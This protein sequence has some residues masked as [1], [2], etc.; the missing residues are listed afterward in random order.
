MTNCANLKGVWNS[1]TICRT[2]A[3]PICPWKQV[4][5]SKKNISN[6]RQSKNDSVK[7]RVSK[8]KLTDGRGHPDKEYVMHIIFVAIAILKWT[9]T[10]YTRQ[11]AISNNKH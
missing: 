11:C 5:S 8:E 1:I 2:I 10:W 9:K 3:L 6:I 4:S 7:L